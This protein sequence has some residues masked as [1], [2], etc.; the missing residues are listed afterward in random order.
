[1][2][3]EA[4]SSAAS[5]TERLLLMVLEAD[6]SAASFTERLLLMVLKVLLLS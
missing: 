5:F 2:M 4:D 1:M 3:L 6:S